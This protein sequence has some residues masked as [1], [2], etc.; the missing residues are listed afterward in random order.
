MI[1]E[2]QSRPGPKLVASHDVLARR[3]SPGEVD[4]EAHFAKHG[5]DDFGHPRFLGR[6]EGAVDAVF[7]PRLARG[8]K[9]ADKVN[10]VDDGPVHY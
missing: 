1:V 8:D 4:R 3:E 2:H 10:E 7:T 6:R 5:G 9:S